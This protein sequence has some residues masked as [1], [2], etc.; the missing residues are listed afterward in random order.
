MNNWPRWILIALTKHFQTMADDYEIALFIEETNYEKH[1]KYLEFRMLGPQIREVS[2]NYYH[3]N[4]EVNILWS[5]NMNDDDFHEQR[6][7]VGTVLKAMDD[8]CVYDDEDVYWNTLTLLRKQNNDFGQIE[9]DSQII[10]GTI[11]GFFEI[12]TGG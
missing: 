4:V 1:T 8:I 9:A 12:K 11:E 7:I 3:I 2:H 10:Q 6:R 5:I